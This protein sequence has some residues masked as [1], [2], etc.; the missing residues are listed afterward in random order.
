VSF[1][2]FWTVLAANRRRAAAEARSRRDR[3]LADVNA[4]FGSST[5]YHATLDRAANVAVPSFA[6]CCLIEAIE[7]ESRPSRVAV[8]HRDP[9]QLR[10]IHERAAD[11]PSLGLTVEQVAGKVLRTGQAE[12]IEQLPDATRSSSTRGQQNPALAPAVGLRSILCVPLTG[13]GRVFGTITFLTAESGRCYDRDDLTTAR[14]VAARASMALENSRLLRATQTV[15]SERELILNSTAEGIYGLDKQGRTTFAN[16]AAARMAGWELGELLG[17]SQHHL[18]HHSYPD[19]SP[20]PPELCPIYSALRDGAP[21]HSDSEV[22]WRKDGTSFPVEYTSTPLRKEGEVVGAVVVFRDISERKRAE[23]ELQQAKQA[24][25]SAS[26]AK[27]SFLAN[28]SHEIRTP[29]TAIMGFTQLLLDPSLS[30]ADRQTFASTIE[31]NGRLLMQIID[32]ILD[33][34]KIESGKMSTERIPCSL[35][36]VVSDVTSMLAPL[37]R[38]KGI[39]LRV[40]AEPKVPA[41]IV[42]DPTRLKQILINIIGN[43]IKFTETGAVEIHCRLLE[44]GVAHPPKLAFVVKD[45][46]R[47]I[48][49]ERQSELFRPFTQADSSTTRKFGGTGLGLALSRRLAEALGGTIELT[50]SMPGDGSTFTITVLAEEASGRFELEALPR[51]GDMTPSPTLRPRTARPQVQPEDSWEPS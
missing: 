32:D 6:D 7:D 45:T 11:Q 26:Q 13:D 14:E 43:A 31:R 39:A 38:D 37:A 42:T 29:L 30:D 9:D 49:P 41:R 4:V 44:S 40:A 19:G 34:S 35:P 33:L 10:L 15:K 20:Y 48:P 21:H 46:G 8:A 28:M 5:D 12:L 51:D 36:G 47:G 25:E 27:S 3:F 2:L 17:K 24:A 22:F 18:L 50:S 1:L 23:H 16:P